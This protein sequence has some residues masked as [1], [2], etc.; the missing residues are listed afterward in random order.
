M[1]TINPALLTHQVS[2]V[3]SYRD[4]P[5]NPITA[6][7]LMISGQESTSSASPYS[8]TGRQELWMGSVGFTDR[9]TRGSMGYGRTSRDVPLTYESTPLEPLFG[10]RESLQQLPTPTVEQSQTPFGDRIGGD[11]DWLLGEL[12]SGYVEAPIKVVHDGTERVV[13]QKMYVSRSFR[14]GGIGSRM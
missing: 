10:R 13:T 5:S 8:S 6:T 2:T 4:R 14:Q 12:Q 3:P 9:F 1:Q 11:L 7:N